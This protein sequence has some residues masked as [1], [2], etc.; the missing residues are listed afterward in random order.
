MDPRE[1]PILFLTGRRLIICHKYSAKF[2]PDEDG[3]WEIGMNIAGAGNLFID[4]KLIIDLSTDPTPGEAFFGLG[5][6]DVRT[7]AKGLKAGQEYNLE[8]RLSNADF[9][10]RGSPFQ[11]WGGIRLGGIREFGGDEAINEAVELAKASDGMTLCVSTH[12]FL[13]LALQQLQSLSSV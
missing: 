9:V 11:C 2:V 8:L 1:L 12:S 5:T 6:V 13:I 10:A 7:V 3:D 4:G